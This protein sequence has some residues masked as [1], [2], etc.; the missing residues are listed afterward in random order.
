MGRENDRSVGLGAVEF[1]VFKPL[2]SQGRCEIDAIF[3]CAAKGEVEILVRAFIVG[4]IGTTAQSWMHIR[5]ATVENTNHIC[6]W[7]FADHAKLRVKWEPVGRFSVGVQHCE[8]HV[9]HL[10]MS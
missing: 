10:T 2:Y 7:D 3:W 4:H 8:R 1:E 5:T 9:V 6:A